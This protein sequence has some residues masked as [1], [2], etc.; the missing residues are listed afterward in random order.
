MADQKFQKIGEGEDT[1]IGM[2]QNGLQREKGIFKK[3]KNEQSM[4]EKWHNF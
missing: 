4:S 3:Q 1:A 2:I